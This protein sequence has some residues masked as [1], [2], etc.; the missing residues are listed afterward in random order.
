M[1]PTL[2]ALCLLALVAGTVV[3]CVRIGRP[4]KGPRVLVGILLA[5][6]LVPVYV[7]FALHLC[8][9]GDPIAQALL[10]GGSAVALAVWIRDRAFAALLCLAA[11]AA[12]AG[13]CDNYNGLVHGRGLTGNPYGTPYPEREMAQDRA[14]AALIE[15]G[16]TDV[17]EY[18]AGWLADLALTTPADA[19]TL[20]E[21]RARSLWHSWF[22]MLFERESTAVA[23]WY[24]GG[25][26]AAAASRLEWR[27][28]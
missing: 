21:Y 14:Q 11:L 16:K 18:P 15:R 12:T 10:G 2:H 4:K 25:A 3:A 9:S 8:Q 27:S 28:K 23:L 20:S 26:P 17:T 7:L 13:L 24:P 5:L 22:T 19:R 6:A 1:G